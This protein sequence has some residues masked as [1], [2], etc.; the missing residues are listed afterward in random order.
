LDGAWYTQKRSIEAGMSSTILSNRYGLGSA[1]CCLMNAM[2]AR[3]RCCDQRCPGPVI[4]PQREEAL[5]LI[6]AG[7]NWLNGNT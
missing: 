6:E 5:D 4:S 1:L 7:R 3:R 2:V